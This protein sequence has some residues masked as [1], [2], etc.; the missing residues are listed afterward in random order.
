M[1][2]KAVF[3]ALHSLFLTSY[4]VYICVF[5]MLDLVE[6]GHVRE[7]ALEALEKW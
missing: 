6:P 2:D 7:E 3:E 4:G 5:N 1:S